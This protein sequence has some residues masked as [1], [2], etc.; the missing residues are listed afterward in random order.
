ML[1]PRCT[2]DEN[3]IKENKHKP[4]QVGLEHVIHQCMERCRSVV[5]AKG[6]HQELEVAVVGAESRYR[7][8]VRMHPHLMITGAEVELG[9]ELRPVQLIHD[10]NRE[11]VLGCLGVE[12]AVVDAETPGAIGLAHEEYRRGE[13]R[14][15]DPN[16]ALSEHDRNLAFELVL[17]QLGVAVRPYGHRGCVRQK[18]DVMIAGASGR[19]AL[20]LV[21]EVTV[22][23]Q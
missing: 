22:L 10:W 23:L 15:R 8:I 14:S 5:E 6:H 19:K 16:D 11:L 1:H 2:I 9:E 3:I 21:E 17:L 4:A 13:R 7:D 12:S 18:V 20:R